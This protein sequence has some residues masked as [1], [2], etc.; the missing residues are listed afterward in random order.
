MAHRHIYNTSQTFDAEPDQQWNRLHSED[1]YLHFARTNSTENSPIFH[2]GENGSADQVH[3]ASQWNNAARSN[4]YSSSSQLVNPPRHQLDSSDPTRDSLHQSSA[5][6]VCTVPETH[7]H[8]ASSSS[9]GVESSLF[10]LSMGNGRGPYKRK[11]PGI[12]AMSERSSTNRYYS[13]GS[14][15]GASSL[16]ELRQEKLTFDAPQ[17]HWEPLTAPPSYRASHLSIGGESS[18]RNVRSRSAVDLES[19][20]C[21]THMPGHYSYHHPSSSRPPVDHPGYLDHTNQNSSAPLPEWTP[22]HLSGVPHGRILSSNISHESGHFFAGSHV[23]PAPGELAGYHQEHISSRNNVASPN[24]HTIP[25]H[26]RGVRSGYA[27]R[28]APNSRV[29][30]GN[31]RM[32]HMVPPNEDLQRVGESHS[33]GHLRPFGPTGWRNGDRNGRPRLS[34]ERYRLFSEDTS[35]HGRLTPEGHMIVDRSFYGNRSMLDHH[36]DMRLDIDSMSYEDLLA[37]GERIGSVNTGVREDLLQ[38]C[39]TESVYC[40]SDQVQEE[41]KCVICLDE[42][43]HMDDVGIVKACGH[44]YHVKCIKKWLSMK[45]SCPICKGPAAPDDTNG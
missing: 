25:S 39:L 20:A 34:S 23:S 42:Y 19:D 15:S 6:N 30:A 13:T 31:V 40:S 28:S 32:G 14:S 11:S 45:N 22:L 37:L 43:Q 12:P 21:R 27:H 24:M 9:Y 1:L 36:R 7:G 38:K 35:T 16:S 3:Y 26:T 29:S 4:G 2:P 10:D 44:D 8:Y 5:P 33:S 18:V 17:N 41:G